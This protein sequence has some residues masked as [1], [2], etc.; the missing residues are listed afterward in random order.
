MKV[1]HPICRRVNEKFDKA[2]GL[3]AIRTN[4]GPQD[5]RSGSRIGFARRS[6]HWHCACPCAPSVSLSLFV[7]YISVSF[8]LSPT[9]FFFLPDAPAEIDERLE[10]V[11]GLCVDR[12]RGTS[13]APSE[14]SHPRRVQNGWTRKRPVRGDWLTDQLIPLFRSLTHAKRALPFSIDTRPCPGS[15]PIATRAQARGDHEARAPWQV[16]ADA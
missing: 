12:H 3:I 14:Q 1:G 13:A 2:G 5:A 15:S 11:A 16:V 4:D 6:C 10:E 7:A 9:T 8:Y